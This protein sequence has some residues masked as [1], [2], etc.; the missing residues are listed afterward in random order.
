VDLGVEL[1]DLDTLCRESDFLTVNAPLTAETN[2]IMGARQFR[3]MKQS[4]YFIN[5]SCAPIAVHAVLV[6]ALKD[7]W[8][9]GAGLDVF[10]MELPSPDDP[11]FD[12]PNVILAPHSLAWTEDLLRGSGKEACRN[13]LQVGRGDVPDALINREVVENPI[14]QRKLD[15]YRY[16]LRI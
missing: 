12:C 14:F 11:I 8:I 4:A 16:D 3:S 2:G 6:E 7:E 15:H 13:I 10:S 9:A 1:V 5:T